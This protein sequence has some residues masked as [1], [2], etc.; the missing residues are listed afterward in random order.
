MIEPLT[1]KDLLSFAHRLA[2]EAGNVILPHFRARGTI[3]NKAAD[4]FDP[5]TEADKGAEAAM[6][7]MIEERFPDH[8]IAGE[9]FASKAATDGNGYC[10][11]LDPI[12]GTKSFIIGMPIWGTLIGLTE[13][14][15]PML[16]MMDQPYIGERFWGNTTGGVFRS[17]GGEQ[18]LATRACAS[19]PDAI[20]AT[21]SPRLFTDEQSD[22]FQ[23]LSASCR[24]TR[25][26][27]DCYQYCLL[28]LG[29]IDIVAEAGL[30]PFDIAP[31]IP[32]IEAAGGIVTSWEGGDAAGGGD[33]LA[34]GDPKLH[35][36]ALNA[37]K[38]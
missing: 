10:W 4:S 30:K 34:V 20:L 11:V 33:V 35:E 6:R 25:F 36:A 22:R 1:D 28:A 21:T 19:L 7:R 3:E 9:E 15:R 16:G 2:D 32:I 27:G 12:D 5:V 26:G 24:L 23:A 14:G 31:L 17:P 8:G 38:R 29:F 18:S 13:N 37:L